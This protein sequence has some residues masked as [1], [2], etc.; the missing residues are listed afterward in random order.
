MQHLKCVLYCTMH[1]KRV[2]CT[3]HC[4]EHKGCCPTHVPPVYGSA[5]GALG[6]SLVLRLVT[7]PFR[8]LMQCMWYGTGSVVMWLEATLRLVKRWRL[9]LSH[10]PEYPRRT[11]SV[12]L[13]PGTSETQ[14]RPPLTPMT[15]AKLA[16]SCGDLKASQVWPSFLTLAHLIGLQL[17]IFYPDPKYLSLGS[18]IP[19][20]SHKPV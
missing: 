16:R 6:H 1:L 17:F 4:I 3:L 14:C 20:Y 5:L 11:A 2:K 10:S 7:I 9:R 12:P 8:Q 13:G 19:Y 18:I 15:L